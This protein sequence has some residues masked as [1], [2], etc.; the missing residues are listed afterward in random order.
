MT[1]IHI[2]ALQ[3][4]SLHVIGNGMLYN[5]L[6]LRMTMVSAHIPEE[7]AYYRARAARNIYVFS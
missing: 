3:N 7:D 5:I 1:G 2:S 6:S 4:A